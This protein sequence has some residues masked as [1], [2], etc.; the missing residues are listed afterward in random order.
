M[1]MLLTTIMLAASALGSVAVATTGGKFW[2][3]DMLY[4]LLFDI[5]VIALVLC[6]FGVTKILFKTPKRQ[7]YP[8]WQR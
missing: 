8:S 6:I 4:Y 7:T 3:D 2:S 5:A 1:F